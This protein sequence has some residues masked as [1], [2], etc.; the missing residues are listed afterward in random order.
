MTRLS[1]RPRP[2]ALDECGQTHGAD[3]DDCDCNTEKHL[4][5]DGEAH[6]PDGHDGDDNAAYHSS[7]ISNSPDH[8]VDALTSASPT[9]E[10]NHGGLR[11]AFRA[12]GGV[13]VYDK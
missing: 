2:D 6:E 4:R 1:I 10:F 3:R 11:A 12:N 7:P 5:Q 8:P 9:E 13:G